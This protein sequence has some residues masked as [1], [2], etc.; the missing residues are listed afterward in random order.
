MKYLLSLVLACCAVLSACGGEGSSSPSNSNNESGPNNT[1]GSSDGDKTGS[2]CDIKKSGNVWKVSYSI[3]NGFEEYT[4]V[5]ESTVDYK[6]YMNDYHMEED[7]VTFTDVVREEIFGSIMERCQDLND[8]LDESSL[9]SSASV[10]VSSTS[11]IGVTQGTVD[12][13]TVIMETMTDIR[14][15]QT[16]KTV[17]IGSQT[18]MAENLNYNTRE[19]WCY[20]DSADSCAKYGRYY[21]WK[22]A[23][24]FKAN[25]CGYPTE[26]LAPVRGVCPRGW[27]MP[28]EKEF[29]TLINAV[30]GKSV[31]GKMLKSTSGWNLD[32]PADSVSSSGFHYYGVDGTDAY[33]FSGLPVDRNA[34]FWSCTDANALNAHFLWLTYS[35][36]DASVAIGSKESGL[37]RCVKD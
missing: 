23:M 16:Y 9:S 27:H 18:W 1:V 13:S 24:A 29:E 11:N 37:V 15:G 31:A 14:N 5:D 19:S 30:G 4:W 32:G 28:T 34:Y 10:E 8:L 3:W 26:N 12:P 33:S 17:T 20:E 35:G 21:T 7:D 2:V 25:G 6:V 36:D 22:A